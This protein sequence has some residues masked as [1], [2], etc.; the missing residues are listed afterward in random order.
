M[1]TDHWQYS[2]PYTMMWH[3]CIWFKFKLSLTIGTVFLC[4]CLK[5][6]IYLV[7][8]MVVF[9]GL[10]QIALGNRT[11][12]FKSK[13]QCEPIYNTNTHSQNI[14][15]AEILT[16][17][18]ISSSTVYLSPKKSA[19]ENASCFTGST[20]DFLGFSSSLTQGFVSSF[21]LS[22]SNISLEFESWSFVCCALVS[23][24]TLV[25]KD[26]RSFQNQKSLFVYLLKFF[27]LWMKQ[28]K[29]HRK[30]T[31][32]CWRHNCLHFLCIYSIWQTEQLMVKGHAQRLTRSNAEINVMHFICNQV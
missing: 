23:I 26:H 12:M 17:L 5:N 16:V 10:E 24:K 1:S 19:S 2:V 14:I 32:K 18:G 25:L 22:S 9:L 6:F 29:S 8:I 3:H 13:Y 20:G 21:E 4:L 27:N 11:K 30:L 31:N 7:L 15:A 28:M